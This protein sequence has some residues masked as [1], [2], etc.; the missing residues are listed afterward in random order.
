MINWDH[1][2]DD[3]PPAQEPLERIQDCAIAHP[4]EIVRVS[5]GR[6]RAEWC[7]LVGEGPNPPSAWGALIAQCRA[8]DPRRHSVMISATYNGRRLGR[9]PIV[10]ARRPPKATPVG[11][12]KPRK[13]RPSPMIGWYAAIA[14]AKAKL[15]GSA[16]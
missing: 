14:E 15:Y 7:G 4:I 11:P 2:D 16:L 1:E 12:P 6:F 13:P 9:C 3:A 10:E 8:P 5:P